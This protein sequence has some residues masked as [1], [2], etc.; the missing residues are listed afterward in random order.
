M[1][2]IGW[3][4]VI[5]AV[6]VGC[7]SE[8][9][10]KEPAGTGC[11]ADQAS[12]VGVCVTTASDPANCGACGTLCASGQQCTAGAC[13]CL[14]GLEA[15]PTGCTDLGSDGQ[16]CGAC[17]VPCGAG[18][19]CMNG[20]CLTATACPSGQSICNQGCVDTST[21]PLHCGACGQACPAGRSCT[22]GSCGC[23]APQVDCGGYCADTMSD[24]AHCG[25]CNNQCGAGA[26]CVAGA[27]VGGGTGGAGSGGT[28]GGGTGSGG[29][30]GTGTGGVLATGGEPG[31]CATPPVGS[32]TAPQV[33]ITEVT[34]PAAVVGNGWEGDTDPIPFALAPMPSGGTRLAWMSNYTKNG[35]STNSQVYVAELD[36]DD[37][38][39]GTPFSMEAYDFSDIAA[40]ADGG[41]VL[42][43]RDGAGSGE[44]HC[45]DVNN[46]CILPSDRPGCYDM[47]LARF[48]NAGQE[49][50]ATKLTTSSAE[51]PSYTAG[52]GWNHTIWWYQHHGRIASDGT[53]Y[54]SYF[55]D[56]ITVTNNSCGG[57]VDIHEGDRMQ[58]VGPSGAIVNH[59]DAF[60]GGCSHSWNTRIVWDEAT[61]RFVMV[62]ATDNNNRVAAP[63]P[64]RTIFDA[65]DIGTLSVGNLVLANGG[66][67]WITVAYQGTIR[68]VRFDEA[69]PNGNITVTD[70][71][72]VATADFSHLVRY[73]LNYMLVSWESGSGLRAQVRDAG[74]GAAVGEEFSIDVP[75]HRYQDFREFPDRS[76]AFAA[77]GSS[78]TSARIARVMPCTP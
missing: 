66:G 45:G 54:A 10:D 34:L 18:T 43:T 4:G 50:W 44:Q 12:C 63:A 19:L 14:A 32:C 36:C 72:T 69:L 13:A 76:V 22:N 29:T 68:L 67:Y 17:G 27:C 3:V 56:A 5:F 30:G 73:G 61:S 65:P 60:D 25:A 47:F 40:D 7:Q 11:A 31:G 51:N 41:V 28:G 35:S 9:G 8:G 78:S 55:C 52:D 24:A 38:I 75:D 26:S 15:C 62:C 37:H 39:V 53:N 71:I 77:Q 59:D 16:S 74:S 33:R 64:Y 57:K 49:V 70:E 20:Q 21:N 46:L 1:K 23:A 58:V 2:R 48:N 42:L 6:L